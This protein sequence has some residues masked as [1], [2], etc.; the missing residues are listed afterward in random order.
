MR[1]YLLRFSMILALHLFSCVSLLLDGFQGKRKSLCRIELLLW[2][3]ILSYF[4]S[5]NFWV[6][7]LDT[8]EVCQNLVQV[9]IYQRNIWHFIDASQR[10]IRDTCDRI[11]LYWNT[12][13]QTTALP[14]SKKNGKQSHEYMSTEKEVTVIL[15]KV[16]ILVRAQWHNP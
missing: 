8:S 13:K 12:L 4:S 5:G 10:E 14:N 2:S 7:K 16:W 11:I 1:L 9:Y 15:G 6:G 3:S